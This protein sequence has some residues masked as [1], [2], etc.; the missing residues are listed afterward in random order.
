MIPDERYEIRNPEIERQL[1]TL[2]ALIEGETP[3]GW[4]WGLFLVPFG[5]NEPEPKGRG[6]VFWISNG[7]REGMIEIVKGWVKDQERKT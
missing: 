2:A 3:E 6:V 4:A 7:Q 5:E 1:R